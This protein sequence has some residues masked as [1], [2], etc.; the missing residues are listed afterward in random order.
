MLHSLETLFGSSVIA[1]DGEI[2]KVY[3]F[4]FDDASWMIRYVM[5]D[6]RHWLNRRDVLLAVTALDQPDWDKRTVH[7]HLTKEQVRHGPDVDSHKP[8]SRQ[9]EIAM[10]EFYGW[11]AYWSD[12]AEHIPI[13]VTA[14]RRFPVREEDDPHLRST[15][16]VTGYTVCGNG[17]EIGRLRNFIVDQDSWHIGYLEV[18]TGDWLL[19]RSVLFPSRWVK[20]ISWAEH[21]V[22]LNHSK[23]G[24]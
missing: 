2:G 20:T 14:G 24:L 5:V 6:V 22:D 15:D 12:S 7:V 18:Q 23:T 11:P 9:Q 17:G 1:T 19:R 3:N 4:L 13:P 8:V 16:A 10:R 21:R